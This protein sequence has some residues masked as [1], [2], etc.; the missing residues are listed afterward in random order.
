[1]IVVQKIFGFRQDREKARKSLE[2]YQGTRI[3]T[4]EILDEYLCEV[5]NEPMERGSISV[6]QLSRA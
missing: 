5:R 6:G 4:E 3:E 1:L 2:F